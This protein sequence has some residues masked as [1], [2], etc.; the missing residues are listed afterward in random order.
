MRRLSRRVRI[1]AVSLVA[2]SLVGV[3]LIAW[4]RLTPHFQLHTKQLAVLAKIEDAGGSVSIERPDWATYLPGGMNGVSWGGSIQRR[5]TP[6]SVDREHFRVFDRIVCVNLDHNLD[7]A[8]VDDFNQLPYLRGVMAGLNAT[9]DE[10]T[11]LEQEFP[12][13]AVTYNVFN[14]ESHKP[15]NNG[16]N[17]N[18]GTR[19]ISN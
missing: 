7:I 19:R 17:R 11:S 1:A 2:A 16:V 10:V 15:A 18:A 8:S 6:Y 3:G 4:W 14:I 9:E 12:A 13:L 5:W